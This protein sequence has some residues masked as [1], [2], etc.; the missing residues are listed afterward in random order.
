MNIN[1]PKWLCRVTD[2]TPTDNGKGIR[3]A[4]RKAELI[5]GH[6]E[7]VKGKND[8]TRTVIVGEVLH[9][10][11]GP[12]AQQSIEALAKLY[13]ETGKKPPEEKTIKTRLEGWRQNNKTATGI[14]LFEPVA[15]QKTISYKKK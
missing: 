12:T 14:D 6:E 4:T 10:L 13:N 9:E 1:E 8:V 2:S 11:T 3:V 15:L 7:D 5:Y